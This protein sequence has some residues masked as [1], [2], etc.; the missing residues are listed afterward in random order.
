M[1]RLKSCLPLQPWQGPYLPANKVLTQH[2][3]Q[4]LCQCPDAPTETT[5][6]SASPSL[7]PPPPITPGINWAKML[8]WSGMLSASPRHSST[9]S[10]ISLPLFPA[11]YSGRRGP[12]TLNNPVQQPSSDSLPSSRRVAGWGRWWSRLHRQLTHALSPSETRHQ[13]PISSQAFVPEDEFR[14]QEVQEIRRC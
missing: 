11:C 8:P 1:H 13:K 4:V 14:R 10:N 7:T 5:N 2:R 3:S 9:A 6:S 12:S